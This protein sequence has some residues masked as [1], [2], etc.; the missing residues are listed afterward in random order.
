MLLLYALTRF[1]FNE[2]K[3]SCNQPA[4]LQKL[5]PL[6]SLSSLPFLYATYLY[7]LG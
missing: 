7:T 6:L 5:M 3:A 1:F 2:T 4:H